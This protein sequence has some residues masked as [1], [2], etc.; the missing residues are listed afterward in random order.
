MEVVTDS[1]SK[2]NYLVWGTFSAKR[3]PSNFFSFDPQNDLVR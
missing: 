3:L 1:N 2:K